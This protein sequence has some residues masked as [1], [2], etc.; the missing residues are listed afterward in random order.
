ME[1]EYTVGQISKICNVA[2]STVIYWINQQKLNSYQTP[3]GY[4]RVPVEDLIRFMNEFGYPLDAIEGKTENRILIVD[5]DEAVVSIMLEAVERE[6]GFIAKA[7]TD[8]Y[9]AGILTERFKPHI[10]ILDIKLR[11]IDGRLICKTLRE[12]PEFQDMKVIAISGKISPEEGDACLRDGFD[13]YF[14]KPLDLN[15]LVSIIKEMVGIKAKL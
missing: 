12:N 6:P 5:D 7:T 14:E 13:K 1:K 4:N 2:R 15:E 8:V 3:G 10:L 9:R 11:G